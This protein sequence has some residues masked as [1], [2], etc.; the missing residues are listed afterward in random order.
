MAVT[1][2]TGKTHIRYCRIL[3]SGHNLSGDIRS[4]NT[5]GIRYDQA[6]ATGWSNGTRQWLTGQGE[7]MLD[8][9]AAI[10]NNTASSTGPTYAGSHI[11]LSGLPSVHAAV[12]VG[13][14]AA[15]DI[16]NPAF[17]AN[18][19]QT[20]YEVS[21]SVG[22]SD[23]VISNGSFYTTAELTEASAVW[24]V[25]LADGEELSST[26]NNGSVDNGASS[27]GGYIAFIHIPPTTGAMGSNDW[28]F[29]I[30]HGTNDSTWA[31]LAN[32]TVDGSSITAER[33]EGSGTVNRYTRFVSTRT[34]GTAAPWCVLIRK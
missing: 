23:P 22:G 24:G 18:F 20:N 32:F 13:I 29:K 26:T 27:S 5:F 30:E 33:L 17:A 28:A 14:R 34:A 6:D 1:P 16:G 9:L 2:L 12:F 31:D 4:V 10:F 19:A 3:A 25:T 8:G 21:G 7:V 15:P 11:R